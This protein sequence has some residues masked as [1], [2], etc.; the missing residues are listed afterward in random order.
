MS[1]LSA[2]M[3][4]LKV[5]GVEGSGLHWAMTLVA[6]GRSPRHRALGRQVHQTEGSCPGPGS[7]MTGAWSH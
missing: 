6:V 5:R 3:E 1:V 4:G 2:D 7:R